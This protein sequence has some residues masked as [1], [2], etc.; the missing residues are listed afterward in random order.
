MT[1]PG[2]YQETRRWRLVEIRMGGG[3]RPAVLTVW[4]RPPGSTV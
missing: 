1:L 3:W 2:F 4:C